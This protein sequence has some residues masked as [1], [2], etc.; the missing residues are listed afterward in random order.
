M[1]YAKSAGE[2]RQNWHAQTCAYRL[3]TG[4]VATIHLKMN[5]FGTL[6]SVPSLPI[7]MA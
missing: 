1:P 4:S 3:Q 7:V 6:T 5:R 2:P